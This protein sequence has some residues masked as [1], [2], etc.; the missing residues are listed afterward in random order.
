MKYVL[1][2]VGLLLATLVVAFGDSNSCSSVAEQIVD[3]MQGR[4]ARERAEIREMMKDGDGKSFV[5]AMSLTNTPAALEEY[6]EPGSP[7][8]IER[9]KLSAATARQMG[10]RTHCVMQGVLKFTFTPKGRATEQRQIPFSASFAYTDIDSLL[11]N[12][13][14]SINNAATNPLLLYLMASAT[15]PKKK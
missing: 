12:D 14:E 11:V 9:Q 4:L 6:L 2:A 15:A 10:S 7:V 8:T 1:I 13:L 5:E 3:D